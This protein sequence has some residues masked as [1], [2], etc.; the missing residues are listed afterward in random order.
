[1]VL[2]SNGC[3]VKQMAPIDSA[4]QRSAITRFWFAS[5]V[6]WPAVLVAARASDSWLVGVLVGMVFTTAVLALTWRLT[7]GDWRCLKLLRR[8]PVRS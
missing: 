5:M 4:D 3:E 2:R 6:F 7:F 1:M 8:Q